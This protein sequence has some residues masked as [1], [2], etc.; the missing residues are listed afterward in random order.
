MSNTD[1]ATSVFGGGYDAEMFGGMSQGQMAIAG[2][3]VIALL[4]AIYYYFRVY[5]AVGSA[6][7]T[8][9]MRGNA[10]S[11]N[12]I[13]GLY[14]GG[15]KATPSDYIGDGRTRDQGMLGL[16]SNPSAVTNSMYPPGDTT[17]VQRNGQT[18]AVSATNN[19][20]SDLYWKC[21]QS[22]WNP[23]AVGEALALAAVGSFYSPSLTED[24]NMHRIVAMAHDPVTPACANA[25]QLPAYKPNGGGMRTGGS[26]HPAAS[27]L[28]SNHP[29]SSP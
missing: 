12:P 5:N 1:G 13:G 11:D 6:L 24:A 19:C 3:A 23:D 9:V 8:L 2:L 26:S 25:A 15:L 4:G 21:S 28:P 20:P 7:E 22:K 14:H 16:L 17:F 29:N 10:G 27:L 18:C